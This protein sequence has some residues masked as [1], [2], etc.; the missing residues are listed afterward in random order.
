M[1][2][3][4]PPLAGPVPTPLPM[5]SVPRTPLSSRPRPP[6]RSLLPRVPPP[7]PAH[8]SGPASNEELWINKYHFLLLAMT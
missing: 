3:L 8:S 5:P 1:R 2:P 4:P 6:S 7:L